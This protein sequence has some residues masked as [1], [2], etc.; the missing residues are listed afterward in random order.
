MRSRLEQVVLSNLLDVSERADDLIWLLEVVFEHLFE[1]VVGDFVG[2]FFVV[3]DFHDC[4][5]RSF[6]KMADNKLV[7]YLPCII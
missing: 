1:L 4:L 5:A 3:L 6:D 7:N 2:D